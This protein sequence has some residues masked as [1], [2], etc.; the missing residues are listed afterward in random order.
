MFKAKY[1]S[2][3]AFKILLFPSIDTVQP[4]VVRGMKYD[5]P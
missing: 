5:I 4:M 3:F 2:S 1:V